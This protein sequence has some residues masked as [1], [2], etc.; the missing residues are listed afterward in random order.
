MRMVRRDE[1]RAAIG[2]GLVLSLLAATG[3]GGSDNSSS[4]PDTASGES[5]GKNTAQATPRDSSAP[6][7]GPATGVTTGGSAN[8]RRARVVLLGTSLTAGLGLDP[9]KAYPALLQAKV[10]S[11]GFPIS[12][13]NAGLSGETSAGALRRANW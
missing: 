12:I 9:E 13:V 6:A 5:T 10:D 2:L 4:K 7:T 1:R 11:A 3:C 8:R